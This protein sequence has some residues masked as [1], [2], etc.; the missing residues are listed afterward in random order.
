MG[1]P[2][3]FASFYA[4][5]LFFELYSGPP[6][7]PTLYA[8][9][10][11]LLA[12]CCAGD[13]KCRSQTRS[14][15]LPLAL[16]IDFESASAFCDV[17]CYPAHSHHLICVSRLQPRQ[18]QHQQQHTSISFNSSTASPRAMDTSSKD[19]SESSTSLK[20]SHI[21]FDIRNLVL[22]RHRRIRQGAK[23]ICERCHNFT[24]TLQ[25]ELI[26]SEVRQVII[27]PIRKLS[28]IAIFCPYSHVNL[29]IQHLLARQPQT[30]SLIRR[31]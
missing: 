24:K 6:C 20:E 26:Q 30:F 16:N 10:Q 31:L 9:N 3:R 7:G 1:A 27:P 8:N 28:N 19:Q 4:Q 22:S 29:L 11:T 18:H 2:G 21:S 14:T 12:Q 13:L 5:L 17:Q 23:G 15:Y 25:L